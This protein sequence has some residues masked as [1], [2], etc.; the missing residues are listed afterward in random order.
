MVFTHLPSAVMLALIPLP[1][2]PAFAMAFLVL[3][4]CSNAMDNAPRTAFL[5]A[6]FLSSERTVAMGIV[7]VVKTSSQSLGP[8]VTGAL[9][10]ANRFWIAFVVAGGLKVL[11]DFGI[12]I[13]FVNHKTRDE[14]VE[15][16]SNHSSENEPNE[17]FLNQEERSPR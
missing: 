17:A 13:M 11:Y 8:V 6:A 12:L 16:I 2:S 15:E 9:S 4:S 7:N 5:A 10:A 1:D 3:R 14:T